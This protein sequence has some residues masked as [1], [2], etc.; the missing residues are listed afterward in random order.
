MVANFSKTAKALE[1]RVESQK[2]AIRV[3]EAEVFEKA[4]KEDRLE[5]QLRES[6]RE[7]SSLHVQVE[8]NERHGGV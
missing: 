7:L 4:N 3:L 2:E 5:E 1:A 8:D 6:R